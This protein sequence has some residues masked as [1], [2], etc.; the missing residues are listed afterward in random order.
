MNILLPVR[1]VKPRTETETR[2]STV[3]TVGKVSERTNQLEYVET[4]KYDE[5][6]N[7]SLHID[8]DGR[9]LQR[10]CNVFGK[11]IRYTGQQYD[12]FTEQYYLR[13]RFYNPAIGRYL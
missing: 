12:E 4:F 8:R 1:S 3:T 6:G 2:Y 13:A 7:L 10:D 11:R 5:E 9:R